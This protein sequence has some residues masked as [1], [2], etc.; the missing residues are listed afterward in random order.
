MQLRGV[1]RLN[2]IERPRASIE[3]PV[4]DEWQEVTRTIEIGQVRRIEELGER[5]GPHA[6]GERR[7]GTQAG[8]GGGG[9]EVGHG[10]ADMA[11]QGRRRIAQPTTELLS[12]AWHP[13][14]TPASPGCA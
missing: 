6:V 7:V 9:E 1:P 12:R 8:V 14:P 4:S 2:G 13:R 3:T 5:A 11:V 10:G